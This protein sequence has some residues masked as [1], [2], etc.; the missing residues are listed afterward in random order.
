MSDWID[1]NDRLPDWYKWVHVWS[2]HFNWPIPARRVE[3]GD[4]KDGWYWDYS[5]VAGL[6]DMGVKHWMPLPEP[7][8][9]TKDTK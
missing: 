8:T 9:N 3:K 7:P 6:I 1:V 2:E 5:R 4:G